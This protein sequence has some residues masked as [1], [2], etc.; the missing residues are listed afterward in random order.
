MHKFNIKS[1]SMPKPFCAF[2][3]FNYKT[4]IELI[5]VQLDTIR[6]M[7]DIVDQARG[8]VLY[9]IDKG[10][11]TTHLEKYLEGRIFNLERKIGDRNGLIRQLTKSF[12]LHAYKE[13]PQKNEDEQPRKLLILE[14][15]NNLLRK[16]ESGPSS[17]SE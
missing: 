10:K 1:N 11:E 5:N 14:I 3:G 8:S 6:Y 12:I 16:G 15:A 2:L 4:Q 13:F 17:D 9:A 7:P